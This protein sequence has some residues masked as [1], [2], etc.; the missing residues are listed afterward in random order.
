MVLTYAGQ[1]KPM[2][3]IEIPEKGQKGIIVAMG[4][5]DILCVLQCSHLNHVS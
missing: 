3:C 1:P 4:T 5:L 2:Y